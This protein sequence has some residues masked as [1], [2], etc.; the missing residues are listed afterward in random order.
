[1]GFT[2]FNLYI[3]KSGGYF[4][5]QNGNYRVFGVEVSCVNKV[6]AD[7]IGGA[8]LIVFAVRGDEG[9]ATGLR[10]LIQKFSAG[11]TADGNLA[12]RLI[13]SHKTQGGRAEL[14]FHMGEEFVQGCGFHLAAAQQAV[15]ATLIVCAFGVHHSNF[16]KAQGACQHI[17]DAGHFHTENPVVAV[18]AEKIAAAFPEIEVKI[19]ESHRDCMKY[20]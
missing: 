17:I 16:R 9:V 20:Y 6:D 18:L 15:G 19:S 7:F 11:A 12:Y 2:D 10:N 4:L 13:A 1:M 5:S 14:V 8:E 3:G